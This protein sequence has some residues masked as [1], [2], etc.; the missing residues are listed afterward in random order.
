MKFKSIFLTALAAVAVF[1]SCQKPEEPVGAPEISLDPA[2]LTIE[3][4]GAT[5]TVAL[6]ATRTWRLDTT[7]PDWLE[8]TPVRGEASKDAQPLT[9]KVSKNEAGNRSVSL[10]FTIGLSDATL[11][12]DQKG[13]KGDQVETITVKEF[14]DKKDKVNEN[15]LR[16]TISGLQ[17]QNK[18]GEGFGGFDLTDDTG[19]IPCAFPVNLND[20]K[21]GGLKDG[22]IVTIRG[23][24]HEHGSNPQMANGKIIDI[25][26]VEL[27]PVVNGT[28]ADV[29]G[30]AV[31]A[32][33]STQE[34]LV[35]G[36]HEQ[37]FMLYDGTDFLLAYVGGAHE[38]W[39]CQCGAPPSP[40]RP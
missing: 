2:T 9:I 38:S 30:A 24:Y 17:F 3:E 21:D 28:I 13:P 11:T 34:L 27:K 18:P 12:V 15:T 33:V 26:E 23:K 10:K 16:G 19:K 20:Y 37:G 40:Y 6:T 39:P 1:A 8:V 29:V 22:D 32:A 35:V 25:Q 7:L 31:G 36:T 5:E 14:L 4:A